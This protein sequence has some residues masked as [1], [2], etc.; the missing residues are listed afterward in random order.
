MSRISP[1]PKTIPVR[2]IET[3]LRP[4]AITC[5]ISKV[6]EF[7]AA[8][9]FDEHFHALLDVNQFGSVKGRSTTLALIKFS[10][11]LFEAADDSA[12]II[13]ILFV[14]FRKAFDL[15]DHNV[16]C[17]KLIESMFPSRLS[18]WSLSFLND[19]CQFVKIG[20]NCSKVMY[21]TAG[22]PQG[23]RAG[24]NDFNVM[25]NDLH[26]ELPYVIYVDDVSVASISTDPHDNSL[27]KA[28]DDLMVW[29]GEN[30]MR[31]NATKTKEMV[32]YF[33]KRFSQSAIQPIVIDSTTI[34]RVS[35][36]K[37]L[38]IYFSS[39][40]K[41]A[42]HVNYI[43]TKATKRFFVICQL[44]RIGIDRA[45]IVTVYCSIVRPILEYA[46]PVWHCGLTQGQSDELENVQKRCLRM[47]FPDLSYADALGV[48]GIERLSERR[49]RAVISLFKEIK[50]PSHILNNLLPFKPV[51]LHGTLRRDDYP[52]RLPVAKTCRR[53]CSF[54]SYC[55]ARRF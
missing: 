48:A 50:H 32:I 22:A 47:I 53:A 5:P 26:F 43:V 7:F 55:V 3:D 39:D 11:T 35:K 42:D 45:A 9:F 15:I 38:G 25:I 28:A 6:A 54:I 23:T 16:L 18:L 14:D 19:R 37:L 34:E 10:H 31:L 52:Y 51:E 17:S 46:S 21:V 30:S 29:C 49:E 20:Q 2:N 40:L 44:A 24:P 36:F 13:R 12:N 41:W 27:Q 33:G 4:I 1:I 8:Q